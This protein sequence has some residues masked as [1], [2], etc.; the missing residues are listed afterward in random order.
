[1]VRN[2]TV[3]VSDRFSKTFRAIS[4]VQTRTDKFQISREMEMYHLL[5]IPSFHQWNIGIF[6][7]NQLAI[8]LR[9]YFRSINSIPWMYIFFLRP[10]PH[11]L[12]FCSFVASVKSRSANPETFF[13]RWLWLFLVQYISL[14]SL[15]S[16]CQFSILV[17]YIFNNF[18]RNCNESFW[19]EL[20]S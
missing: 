11:S 7:K 4:K 8:Y 16:D 14:C 15:V 5:K 12:D 9:V 13:C 3:S 18:D 1:M 19:G 20:S 6:V 2:L 10:V 17:K